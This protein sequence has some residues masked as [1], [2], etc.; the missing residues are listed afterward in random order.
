MRSL[1]YMKIKYIASTSKTEGLI[2]FQKLKNE[3]EN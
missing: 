2:L 3:L 1:I